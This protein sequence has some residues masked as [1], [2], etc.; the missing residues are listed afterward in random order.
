MACQ[1]VDGYFMPSSCEIVFYV[2]SYLYFFVRRLKFFFAHS[3]IEYEDFFNRFIWPID[4]TLIGIFTLGQSELENNS[5]SSDLQF[6]SLNIICSLVSYPGHHIFF[7][8]GSAGLA[9]LQGI[10][11]AYPHSPA[12]KV[13]G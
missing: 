4:R 8:G 6:W 13:A 7:C 5:H 3:P 11:L 10:Q 2:Y 12:D 9:S 1:L